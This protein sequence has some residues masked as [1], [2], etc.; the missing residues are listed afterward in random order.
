MSEPPPLILG[1]MPEEIWDFTFPYRVD[2]DTTGYDYLGHA[3]N[4]ITSPS[5]SNTSFDSR[6][7]IPRSTC[8]QTWYSE[9]LGDAHAFSDEPKLFSRSTGNTVDP[10]MF[11]VPSGSRESERVSESSRR[12]SGLSNVGSP[13]LVCDV[14][15]ERFKG[16]YRKKNLTRH[17]LSMHGD[18]KLIVCE[19][20]GCQRSYKRSD[21]VGVHKRKAHPDIAPPL[22]PR[23]NAVR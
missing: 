17:M 5:S 2:S 1:M 11:S 14:C 10:S 4:V 21:A 15:E 12:T 22:L 9:P 7:S 16:D 19:V 20:P 6:N 3:S 8:I 18:N 13:M 23:K